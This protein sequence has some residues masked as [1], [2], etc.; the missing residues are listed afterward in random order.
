MSAR[1][2]VRAVSGGVTR[3]KV[4]TIVIFTVLLVST[5]AAT[6]GLGLLLDS[7]GPFQHAF[8][9]QRGAD[10]AASIDATKVTA[11]QL[12]DTQRL[13]QVTAAAGPF[14]EAAIT[15]RI[16]AQGGITM[17]PVTVAGRASPG[18][19]ADDLT[20]DAGRW[21]QRPGEIVL[22][23][24][25]NGAG[26][27]AQL[28]G[29]QITVT[30]APGHP[31]LTVVGV[32]K[33]IT[34]TA[35]GW[36]LPAQIAALRAPHAPAAA[37]MLYRFHH[38]GTQAQISADVTALTRALPAGTLTGTS[39]WLTV[40]NQEDATI[41]IIVPF[42]MA[43]GLIGL[44]MAVVIVG[45]VVN[46][47]VVSGYR[48]IGVLKSIGF[49]PLQVVAAYVAQAGI[50]ALAG[51]LAGVVLGNVLSVPLLSQTAAIY[52]VGKLLVPPSADITV[53]LLMCALA[54]LAALMPALR[55]GRLSAVQAIATGRA[56]R[57]GRGYTAHRLLGRLPAPRPVTIGLAAPLARPSRV[58]V[59]MAAMLFGATAV[60]FAAGLGTSLAKAANGQSHAASEQVQV[61][62]AMHPGSRRPPPHAGPYQTVAPAL[63]A[64]HGTLHFVAEAMPMVG[65]S[66]LTQPVPTEAFHGDAAWTGYDMISGRWYRARGE[67]VVNTGFLTQ[68]GKSVG[69]SITLTFGGKQ[70]TARIVG[71]VF[72]PRGRGL[73][74]MITS[75]QTLGG[76]S[77]G[78]TVQQYDVGLRP[79]T[80]PNA[81]SRALNHA[82]FPATSLPPPPAIPATRPSPP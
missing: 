77:A 11:G 52:G 13:P 80:D 59:T 38:A 10:V 63:R 47:A 19:P 43:F 65:V 4:Q 7:N 37:Q 69:D 32:A 35:D 5:A 49:T 62:P 1:P 26:P 81:Y 58:A 40:K 30:S 22:S 57:A 23:R 6:L 25:F 79:G 76:A 68:T 44:V 41:A 51:T 50:P 3:R 12:A 46:G 18:G 48:R 67:V 60:I 55:A 34:D 70:I 9:T 29:T 39:S 16:S 54:G 61:V 56:P 8:A 21:A 28:I 74:A 71:E 78:L 24:D 82:L 36:V 14:A 42:V 45:N 27:P 53:P 2:V 20:L 31:A 64:Q 66:G 75:W 15:P 17:P 73:P 33:S 72:D